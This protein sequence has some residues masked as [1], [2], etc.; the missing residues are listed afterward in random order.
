MVKTLIWDSVD[1]Y[2]HFNTCY[3]KLHQ[4]YIDTVKWWFGSII[5]MIY[6]ASVLICLSI[7][8]PR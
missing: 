5:Q 1:N 8:I 4:L 2:W 6:F 3:N 7:I